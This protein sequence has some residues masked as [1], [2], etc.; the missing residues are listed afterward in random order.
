MN[1]TSR[2]FDQFNFTYSTTDSS[3]ISL[4]AILLSSSTLKRGILCHISAANPAGISAAVQLCSAVQQY[5]AVPTVLKLLDSHP[6][7]LYHS[8]MERLD[9]TIRF[10]LNIPSIGRPSRLLGTI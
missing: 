9:W 8:E 10:V 1:L 3:S 7:S 6:P 2:L 5:N 4:A